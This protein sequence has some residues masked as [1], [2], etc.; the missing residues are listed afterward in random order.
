MAGP[1]GYVECLRALLRET[2]QL[3]DAAV[4]EDWEQVV[5]RLEARQT[6]MDQV[7]ALPPA[8]RE[9]EAG[10]AR[11]LLQ[12]VMRLDEETVPRVLTT[13]QNTRG[14]IEESRLTRTTI[15]AYRRTGHARTEAGPA[16]FLD[17]QQ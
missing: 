12:E 4:A 8:L 11:E 15:D 6:L 5:L 2:Q 3:K 16:R 9:A 17:K 13:L 7:D 14:A 10:L 1:Q